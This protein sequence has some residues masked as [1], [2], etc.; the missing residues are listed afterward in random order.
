MLQHGRILRTLCKV[1]EARHIVYDSIYIVCPEWASPQGTESRL[2]VARDWGKEGTESDDGVSF[3]NDENVVEL[4]AMVVQPW[5]YAK[6]HR[7]TV[8]FKSMN[9]LVCGLFLNFFKMTMSNYKVR[10]FLESLF[11]RPKEP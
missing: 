1:K 8:Y 2:M 11:H 5:K 7:T 9:F 10:L 6:N 3:C 4:A